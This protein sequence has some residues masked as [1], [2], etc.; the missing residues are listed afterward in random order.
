MLRKIGLGLVAA[1]FLGV[2]GAEAAPNV[3]RQI[4]ATEDFFEDGVRWRGAPTTYVFR[5]AV[6]VNNGVIEVCGVGAYR[7]GSLR[8]ETRTILRSLTV[9]LGDEPYLKDFTFFAKARNPNKLVGAKANCA[10]TGKAPP[11]KQV[12]LSVR[13]T[14]QKSFDVR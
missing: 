2:A 13:N 1:L 7:S 11:S 3:T 9:F 6:L 10:S 5:F 12:G 14:G 8:A 4:V